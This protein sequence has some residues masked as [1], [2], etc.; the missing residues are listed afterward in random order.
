MKARLPV[1]WVAA[2]LLAPLPGGRASEAAVVRVGSE[3][4]FP[5]YTFVD[6]DGRAAGF[7][8]DLIRAVAETMNLQIEVTTGTWDSV[9][10]RLVAGQLDVLPIV[11]KLPDR[12]RLVGKRQRHRRESG[13]D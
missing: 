13:R 1:L 5:P 3:V 6:K 2:I 4:E 8:V 7:S 9:W 10:G 12:A 11:A